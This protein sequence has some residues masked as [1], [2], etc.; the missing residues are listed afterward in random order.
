MTQWER[1]RNKTKGRAGTSFSLKIRVHH[2]VNGT[3]AIC[4]AERGEHQEFGAL[5]LMSL[6]ITLDTHPGDIS[7]E[8]SALEWKRDACRARSKPEKGGNVSIQQ[9]LLHH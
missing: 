7:L 1:N 4:G 3:A 9:F 5:W 8:L 6:G 2:G